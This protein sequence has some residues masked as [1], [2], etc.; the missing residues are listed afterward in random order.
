MICI[1]KWKIW[2]RSK[3]YILRC[4]S[5][6]IHKQKYESVSRFEYEYGSKNIIK[7]FNTSLSFYILSVL[8][9]CNSIVET[10]GKHLLEF[11][12]DDHFHC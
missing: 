7:V 2:A 10:E 12:T 9:N 11:G 1:F 8:R 5:L 6:V 3:K 4:F